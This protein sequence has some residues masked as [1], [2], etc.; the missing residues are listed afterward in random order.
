MKQKKEVIGFLDEIS[1]MLYY[2]NSFTD[3]DIHIDK[4]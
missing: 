4:K 3:D 2:E 1:V